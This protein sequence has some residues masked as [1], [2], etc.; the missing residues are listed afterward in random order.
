MKRLLLLC[1]LFSFITSAM[2]AQTGTWHDSS[3]GLTWNYVLGYVDYQ[4]CVFLGDYDFRAL[5]SSVDG[6]LVIPESF[7]FPPNVSLPVKRIIRDAFKGC[8]GITSIT[9]PSQVY[10]IAVHAFEGC[11]NLTSFS[12]NVSNSWYSSVEGFLCNKSGTDLLLAPPGLTMVTIPTQITTVESNAFTYCDNLSVIALPEGLTH[13]QSDAFN[14]CEELKVV[15]FSKSIKVVSENAFANTKIDTVYCYGTPDQWSLTA[16]GEMQSSDYSMAPIKRVYCSPE[17]RSAWETYF[18]RAGLWP[19]YLTFSSNVNVLSTLKDAGEF[20]LIN[21][22]VVWGETVEVVATPKEGYLFLGWSSNVDEIAGSNET[23]SFTM[24]EQPVT[25]VAS[26]I[27]KATRDGWINDAIEAKVEKGDLITSEQLQVM[28]MKMPVIAVE[29]GSVTL[30]LA[31]QSASSLDGEWQQVEMDAAEITE[32][33][34][35]SVSVPADEKASF[36][37]FV[38][39]QK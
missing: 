4:T 13:I 25:L 19:E 5:V 2:A 1:S 34:S 18:S 38:V 22:E 33:G 14:G 10:E 17:T 39:P 29:E 26:F 3:T 31:L 7:T 32:E 23:I 16:F 28:A 9:I 35:I 20:S 11:S 12:V 24:P 21:Q 8:T 6:D 37:K 15:K 30:D 27:S 36:Y